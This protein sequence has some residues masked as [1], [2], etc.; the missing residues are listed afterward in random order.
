MARK[1]GPPLDLTPSR[2]PLNSIVMFCLA[3]RPGYPP[4]K[5]AR[6]TDYFDPGRPDGE[7][8][9]SKSNCRHGNQQNAS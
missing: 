3:Q 4:K 7:S 1:K 9:V 8:G 6:S 2:G 5:V